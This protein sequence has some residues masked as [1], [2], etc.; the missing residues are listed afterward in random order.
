[1]R[2]DCDENEGS[3]AQSKRAIC[4][5]FVSVEFDAYST[6]SSLDMSASR[7]RKSG[8]KAEPPLVAPNCGIATQAVYAGVISSFLYGCLA[9]QKIKT[10]HLVDSIQ[11][12]G[13]CYSLL[14]YGFD[15][16]PD[17]LL[18][19]VLI[20]RLMMMIVRIRSGHQLRVRGM[21]FYKR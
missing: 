1:M 13:A 7:F 21:S 10:S 14:Y 2:A 17:T 12:G 11:N 4:R 15:K 20:L 6:Y 5:R 16:S 9:R 19:I 8:G 3:P 18:P